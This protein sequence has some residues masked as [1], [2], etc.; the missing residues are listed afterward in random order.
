MR[1]RLIGATIGISALLLTAPPARADAIDGAWC[2]ETA[3]RIMINGPSIV[4][5]A[6]TKTKGDYSRHAFSYVVPAGEPGAGTTVEMRLLNEQTVQLR[7]VGSA[8][9]ETWFRCG[10]TISGLR[11]TWV[12]A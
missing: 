6:G 3:L 2:H 1:L 8:S 7:A 5:P 10:P 4:T 9:V 12:P 11:P